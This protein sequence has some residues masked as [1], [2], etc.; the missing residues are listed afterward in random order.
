[1]ADVSILDNEH[2]LFVQKVISEWRVRVGEQT[3]KIR[4]VLDNNGYYQFSTS[5]YYQG[6]KLAGPVISSFANLKS[7][8]EALLIAERQIIGMY[9]PND[10]NATWIAN[11]SF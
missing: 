5:H 3:I 4:I 8:E 9:D 7:E 2:F 11:S 6:S 1:M 10:E